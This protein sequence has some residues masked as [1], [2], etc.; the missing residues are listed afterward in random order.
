MASFLNMGEKGRRNSI[1][2]TEFH[3]FPSRTGLLAAS[4]FC[5]RAVF[6]TC[7]R[8]E[9]PTRMQIFF[10]L[11]NFCTNSYKRIHTIVIQLCSTNSYTVWILYQFIHFWYKLYTNCITRPY[12]HAAMWIARKPAPTY[13]QFS[14]FA[15]YSYVR[16]HLGNDGC[17]K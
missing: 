6:A 5:R 4:S 2:K 7:S 11:I 15:T 13:L 14:Q 9:I 8:V 12:C 17:L 16:S 3:L 10:S 1:S